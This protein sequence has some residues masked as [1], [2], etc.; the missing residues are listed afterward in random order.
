ME[1]VNSYLFYPE[2]MHVIIMMK[3]LGG[4]FCNKLDYNMYFS[5]IYTHSLIDLKAQ[6]H[7]SNIFKHTI[8]Y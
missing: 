2:F 8:F 6:M 4:G 3:E 5:I 1:R 7:I